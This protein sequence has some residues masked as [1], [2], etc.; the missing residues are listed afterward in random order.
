MVENDSAFSLEQLYTKGVHDGAADIHAIASTDQ[1]SA[2]VMVWNYYDDDLPS[3]ST[4]VTIHLNNLPG[5]KISLREY[6]IDTTHSNAYTAWKQMGS[7]QQVTKEQ[8]ATLEKTG[9]LQT[10]SNE[11]GKKIANRSFT[12]TIVL[13]RQGV[14]L[15]EFTW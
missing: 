14:S 7:P 11:E 4:P 9:K 2:W 8:Y 3:T 10:L 13:P 6:R 5:N 15:L 12:K 1:K